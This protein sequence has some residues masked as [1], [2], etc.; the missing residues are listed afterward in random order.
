[1][2]IIDKQISE[3]FGNVVKNIYGEYNLKPVE[4]AVATNEKFG[5]FQTNIAMMNSKIIGKNPRAIAEEI[6]NAIPENNIIE[7]L[8][9]AGPGFINIFLKDEF[10]GDYIKKATTEGIDFS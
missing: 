3:I 4:I 8:E 10:L 1:M 2:K 7:K 9:I 6:L 5:D